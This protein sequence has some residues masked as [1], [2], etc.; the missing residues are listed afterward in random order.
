MKADSL[1]VSSVPHPALLATALVAVVATLG[2]LYAAGASVFQDARQEEVAERGAEVMPFDLDETTH[3]F[4]PTETGGVQRVV[5]DDPTDEKQVAL[6]RGHL[7]EEAESFRRGDLSD[8][9]VIHGEDMP[10]LRELETGAERIEIRYSELSDGA[11][12]EYETEDPALASALH[13]WFDAQ[14]SD[15]GGHAAEGG[16]DDSPGEGR[17]AIDH[18]QHQEHN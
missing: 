13:E 6:I 9:A 10:G 4:E 7:E 15:H 12:I 11:Q 16:A 1:S 14:L 8:P 2:V 18:S 3:V 5:A 17:D